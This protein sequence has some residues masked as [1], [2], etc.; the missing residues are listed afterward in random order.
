MANTV[1]MDSLTE[2]A[3]GEKDFLSPEELNQLLGNGSIERELLKGR[4]TGENYQREK[5][6]A[7]ES[8]RFVGGES[9]IYWL[10]RD[11]D[12]VKFIGKQ[13]DVSYASNSSKS[14]IVRNRVLEFLYKQ[15]SRTE[16]HLL[17]PEDDI[18]VTSTHGSD[19]IKTYYDVIP[20]C[21]E[22]SLKNR[23]LSYQELR[24]HFLPN[25][26][27]AL[28]KLHSAGFI[29]GDIKP[30][31][32]YEFDGEYV[33]GDFGTV[34]IEGGEEEYVGTRTMRGTL[35]FRAPEI[36]DRYAQYASDYYS[37]G[38]CLI[39]LYLGKHPF[40]ELIDRG[41][42]ADMN[43]ALSN[44]G[45][46]IPIVLTDSE[47]VRREK[48]DLQ[49]LVTALTM[50][51]PKDRPSADEIREWIENPDSFRRRER[52]VNNGFLY[53]FP[54]EEDVCTSLE[55]LLDRMASNW[56]EAKRHLVTLS[57]YLANYTQTLAADLEELCQEHGNRIDDFCLA[58][59][60]HVLSKNNNAPVYW[61]GKTFRNPREM[62]EAIAKNQFSAEDVCDLLKC[63]FLS[64]KYKKLNAP[65]AVIE[66]IQE[67]ER[68]VQERPMLAFYC[69]KYE[70]TNDRTIV[71]YRKKS[72]I[73]EVFL[74]LMKDVKSFYMDVDKII[75]DEELMAFIIKKG[76]KKN[77]FLHLGK[78]RKNKLDKIDS[79]FTLMHACCKDKRSVSRNYIDY[80]PHSYTFW[81]KRNLDLYQAN[82]LAGKNILRG[83]DSV[84]V[85]DSFSITD[86]KNIS[87]Q[88]SGYIDSMRKEQ[89]THFQGNVL[90]TFLGI[91]QEVT[92]D[93]TSNH[94]DAFF[95]E[96]FLGMSV[97]MGYM[98]YMGLV[99]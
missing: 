26:L 99:G 75:Y 52:M 76:Y 30:D 41:N 43:H 24:E 36:M 77:V 11:R 84:M 56:S 49:N 63:G 27:T 57:R 9:Q 10:I 35:G 20:Y 59:A 3:M 98:R 40:Q 87:G 60:L 45:Y 89:E 65:E 96:D 70:F 33:L 38:C 31:N 72:E 7:E 1:R 42:E 78:E 71:Q 80:G 2:V 86:I 13:Y 91:T 12:Q 81:V 21:E 47:Q 48:T 25:L 34:R 51:A 67:L 74:D 88:I 5:L 18:V 54:T 29:H 79:F 19:E 4:H 61:R 32:L 66:G 23:K 53:S 73:D 55:Q 92:Y 95:T 16:S 44:Y 14:E 97:P 90:L 6:T 8:R 93:I 85:D 17:L 82:N 46:E 68:L 62:S 69:V 50:D 39:T 83:I 22:G 64:W 94:S 58:K 28:D 15:N 37:L